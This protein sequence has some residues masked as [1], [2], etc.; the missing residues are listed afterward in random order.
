M[1]RWHSCINTAP[2][3]TT[4]TVGLISMSQS[5]GSSSALIQEESAFMD[6]RTDRLSVTH[7]WPSVHPGSQLAPVGHS[8]LAV[9][10]SPH[11]IPPPPEYPPPP[12]PTGPND[13]IASGDRQEQ[14]LSFPSTGNGYSDTRALSPEEQRLL[15][16]GT[17]TEQSN[18]SST[19]AYYA[20]GG[21]YAQTEANTSLVP[22]TVTKNTSHPPFNTSSTNYFRGLD[23]T[24]GAPGL[25][26][27][28]YQVN[29]YGGAAAVVQ[30]R[31]Q[32][33]FIHRPH[34][35]H[36]SGLRSGEG[37]SSG[38]STTSGL[39]SGSTKF[40]NGGRLPDASTSG[41]GDR[42]HNSTC[43]KCLTVSRIAD[44]SRGSISGS[45]SSS[46]SGA[47]V[48]HKQQQ[49][50]SMINSVNLSTNPERLKLLPVGASPSTHPVLTSAN[51]SHPFANNHGHP[52]ITNAEL[53]SSVSSNCV[54]QPPPLHAVPLHSTG[55]VYP[56]HPIRT[57]EHGP[58]VVCNPGVND[59][60]VS[61]SSAGVLLNRMDQL[62]NGT[63]G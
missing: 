59:S 40:T 31:S 35:S 28:N 12:L 20:S 30:E 18:P 13:W 56:H 32:P 24:Y 19:S 38:R 47:R 41:R 54:S 37:S 50:S 49:I 17:K 57:A 6:P 27:Q 53:M 8:Y 1:I 58:L 16:C 39:G 15:F 33:A 29:A 3:P 36:S 48:S 63:I 44:L 51:S 45:D 52:S 61:T 11:P 9:P 43:F 34:R 14:H 2:Q 5:I 60:S 55:S 10:N 4:C 42:N 21:I 25:V 62:N 23:T 26:T 7:R 22:Y 46:G